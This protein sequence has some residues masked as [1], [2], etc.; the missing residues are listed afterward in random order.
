[1]V[2]YS[3]YTDG[4]FLN[5]KAIWGFVVF[6][7]HEQILFKNRGEITDASWNEGRQIAG[8]CQGVIEA[9]KWCRDNDGCGVIHYDYIGLK[10][11]IADFWGD[12]PWRRNKEYTKLYREQ[13]IELRPFLI[14]MKWVK[15]HSG[16]VGNEMV[17]KYIKSYD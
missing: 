2:T 11:W 15:G 8:E 13:M 10:N 4:S 3:I 16:V 6:N 7:K 12:T 1:M 14:D 9:L 5:G 17:D